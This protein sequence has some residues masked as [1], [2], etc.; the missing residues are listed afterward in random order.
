MQLLAQLQA[1]IDLLLRQGTN[2][3]SQ[4]QQQQQRRQQRHHLGQ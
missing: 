1:T 2:Q 4:Q 3:R